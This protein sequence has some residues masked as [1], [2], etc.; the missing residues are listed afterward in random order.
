MGSYSFHY[1][2][3]DK[4]LAIEDKDFPDDLEALDFAEARSV[5]A[6]IVVRSGNRYVAR[7]KKNGEPPTPT[8]PQAG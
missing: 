3:K 8:D 2:S 1:V 5:C 7:I 6:D 4:L